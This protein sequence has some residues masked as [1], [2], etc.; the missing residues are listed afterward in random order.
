MKYIF[1][2]ETDGLLKEVSTI[3]SCVLQNVMDD[4]L[5]SCAADERFTPIEE[6]ITLINNASVLI[7]HNII[8]FDLPVLKKLHGIDPKAN[9]IDTLNLSR[10]LWPNILEL[11][12]RRKGFPT[13]LVGKHSLEAWGARL[14]CAKGDFGKQTDWKE[15]S[16]PMQKYCEQDVI[17]TRKLY[18]LCMSKNYA[19]EAIDIEIEFQKIIT[20]Q[21]ING[22]TFNRLEAQKMYYKLKRDQNEFRTKIKEMV[23]DRRI[24][25]VFV[26]KRDNV[27]KGYFKDQPY[28]K[29]SHEPFNPGSRT[30]IANLFIGKYKWEP[31]ELTKTGRPKCSA[32]I[33]SAL[34]YE[35]AEIISKYLTVSKLLGM[36]GDGDV[37]WLKLEVDGKLHG[38]VNTNGAVTGRI[39]ASSPNLA[40]VP[41]PGSF[42]GEECRKLFTASPGMVMVGADAKALELRCFGHFLYQYDAGDYI[43]TLL[44][45]DI[46]TANQG[47]AGLPTR[48]I[49]KR[50]IF[51]FNYGAGD[52][53]LGS[54]IR[55][56]ATK[57]EQKI[58]GSAAR[59]RLFREIP[60]IEQLIS[61]VKNVA[62]KRGYLIG[63]DGR[64][65]HI[66]EEYR[67]LN[68][69]LQ[70]AGAILI[71]KATNIFY[72]HV[73]E[74]GLEVRQLLHIYDEIDVECK[75][76]IAEEVGKLIV[77]S[78][79]ESG[80]FFNFKCP[81]TGNY[82]VG[83][84][85][86]EI[87]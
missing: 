34:P 75:P 17:V 49:A 11:D 24:E 37:S 86:A 46:H 32:D 12:M 9:V 5:T 68:T 60:A 13:N 14:H 67:A 84:N 87:H 4:T 78:M 27:K 20:Q 65:L 77:Q 52:A 44:E 22:V 70:S 42:M 30:Q 80:K 61:S 72:K 71:K 63:I 29:V 55:P 59:Y 33:I 10:L 36:I 58:L 41:A 66:R 1:D 79:E 43:K 54:L 25:K 35:E 38:R 18:D 28:V 69:L 6:G 47:A 15:W 50:F 16:M 56:G 48:T 19:Q 31:L 73:E 53:L 40:Q 81:I 26:P 21:E 62:S 82:S 85:W 23:P 3:H 7:G 45:A 64:H 74:R 39:T 51:S 2:L 8:G 57:E 76:E 83:N